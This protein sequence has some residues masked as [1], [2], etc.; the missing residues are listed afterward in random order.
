MKLFWRV[1][2]DGRGLWVRMYSD[3]KGDYYAAL[4]PVANRAEARA[5]ARAAFKDFVKDIQ[6]EELIQICE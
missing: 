2:R 6:Q 5:E 4:R 3:C 1:K